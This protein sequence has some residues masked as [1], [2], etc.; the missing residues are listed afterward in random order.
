MMPL[1]RQERSPPFLLAL[2]L[3][4]LLVLHDDGGQR[5]AVHS[6][7]LRQ[8][9]QIYIRSSSNNNTIR[10]VFSRAQILFSFRPAITYTTVKSQIIQC[11]FLLSPTSLSFQRGLFH[12]I[13]TWYIYSK[14][15]SRCCQISIA[16][17]TNRAISIGWGKKK[18][19]WPWSKNTMEAP[20]E[21]ERESAIYTHIK[22]S[23]MFGNETKT[24]REKKTK[25]EKMK[26]QKNDSFFFFGSPRRRDVTRELSIDP[27]LPSLEQGRRGGLAR[28][29]TRVRQNSVSSTEVSSFPLFPI[30]L[31]HLSLSPDRFLLLHLYLLYISPSPPPPPPIHCVCVCCVPM[32]AVVDFSPFPRRSS[33]LP[34][35]KMAAGASVPIFSFWNWNSSSS[36][37]SNKDKNQ[38]LLP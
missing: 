25:S 21:R 31:S 10:L 34:V 17:P 36:S 38:R 30:S 15:K 24:G 6:A 18:C 11:R 37:S 9:Y 1:H 13:T 7:W 4:L 29:N 33:F 12:L 32:L 3:L 35:P 23:V 8:H 19:A 22:T 20:Q 28:P 5:T 16:A 2:L 26:R 14:I 27:P